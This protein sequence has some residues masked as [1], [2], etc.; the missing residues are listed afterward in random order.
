MEP[1]DQSQLAT[2]GLFAALEAPIQKSLLAKGRTLQLAPGEVLYH[3]GDVPRGLYGLVS[4][5]LRLSAEDSHGKQLLFGTIEAGWWCG[6]IPVLDGQP[7]AQTATAVEPSR[8]LLIPQNAL[9]SV[10][11]QHPELYRH[12]TRILCRRIRIAGQMLEEAAFYDLATRVASQLLRLCRIHRPQANLCLKLPQEEIAS[13]LG[14]TRQSLYRVL[15]QWQQQQWIELGYGSLT[16]L[17]PEALLELVQAQ[18][19]IPPGITSARRDSPG[20]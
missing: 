14:I 11:E 9:D 3:R 20:Y 6:E 8:L 10:L 4:G 15:K 1:V 19:A 7:Y 16:L 2:T 18:Q 13:M 5:Q 12:F 17:R